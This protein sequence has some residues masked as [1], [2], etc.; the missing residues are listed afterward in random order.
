MTETV[1]PSDTLAPAGRPAAGSSVSDSSWAA[2]LE[3][4]GTVAT[5]RWVRARIVANQELHADLDRYAGPER[6][7]MA[8]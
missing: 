8:P 3:V 5:I 7:A 6:D 1:M 2:V 4:P